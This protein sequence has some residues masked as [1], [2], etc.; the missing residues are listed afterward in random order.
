MVLATESARFGG[1]FLFPARQSYAESEI[2]DTTPAKFLP[3]PAEFRTDRRAA[4]RLRRFGP[5]VKLAA[6]GR[7]VLAQADRD[8]ASRVRQVLPLR[9]VNRR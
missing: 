1:P 4:F 6:R 2:S 5:G 3:D 8:H 9:P 7:E